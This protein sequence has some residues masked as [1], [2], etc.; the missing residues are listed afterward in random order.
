MGLEA[1]VRQP[2]CG[3]A[4]EAGRLLEAPVRQ[5]HCGAAEEAGRLLRLEPGPVHHGR[6]PQ[7]G[8]PPRVRVPVQQGPHLQGLPH[9]QLVPPLRHR[10]QRRG[11]GVSGQA[12]PPVA[13]PLPHPGGGGPLRGGGH[14]PAGDHAGRH[15]CGRQPQRRAVSGH[16]G[17]EGPSWPTSTWTWSSAPAA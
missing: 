12:R 16:R 1:A 13:H 17:Q 14:H 8:R 2:H 15:R 4:E 3:A 6:G 9:H 7:Q 5:P 10:P 11:G